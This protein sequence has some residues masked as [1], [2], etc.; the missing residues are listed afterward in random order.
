[1]TGEFLVIP[2]EGAVLDPRP[3]AERRAHYLAGSQ[4]PQL[5]CRVVAQVGEHQVELRP[6]TPPVPA[7]DCDHEQLALQ[8]IRMWYSALP[9][10]QT[11]IHMAENWQRL[12]AELHHLGWRRIS[13]S[14]IA[15]QVP[16]VFPSSLP[17]DGLHG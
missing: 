9:E 3:I 13:P 14:L 8:R 1:M 2:V 17:G 15:S 16:A 11:V 12:C 7:G 4:G 6:E 10:I 5:I